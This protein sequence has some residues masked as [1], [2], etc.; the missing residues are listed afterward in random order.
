VAKTK[1]ICRVGS[2]AYHHPDDFCA[3]GEIQVE[4][5]SRAAICET[6]YPR[7]VNK[8]FGDK[9][10]QPKTVMR[11][12]ILAEDDLGINMADASHIYESHAGNLTPLVTCSA[13]E[14]RHWENEVCKARSIIIDGEM[15]AISEETRCKTYDPR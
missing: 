11:E 5:F 1:T 12:S 13:V 7:D 9:D 4:N 6:F 15:A 10:I 2:C 3:A 14:C 8:Q